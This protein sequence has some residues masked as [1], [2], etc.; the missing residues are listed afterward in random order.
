MSA[1]DRITFKC[2]QELNKITFTINYSGNPLDYNGLVLKIVMLILNTSGLLHIKHVGCL[3]NYL[4]AAR[5]PAAM[6][7]S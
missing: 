5:F 2:R 4:N 3:K 7:V 6:G 1:L